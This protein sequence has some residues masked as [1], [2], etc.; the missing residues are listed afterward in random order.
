MLFG[1]CNIWRCTLVSEI[2]GGAA[3]GCTLW[4]GCCTPFAP[5]DFGGC[6]PFAPL[7][8]GAAPPG[9]GGAP[10]LHPPAPSK[11]LDF[12]ILPMYLSFQV[13]L[14]SSV[15]WMLEE[16]YHRR[17]KCSLVGMVHPHL[18]HCK[19]QCNHWEI[20]KWG[21]IRNEN[22]TFIS[23]TIAMESWWHDPIKNWIFSCF[24]KLKSF[25]V[26]E[27]TTNTAGGRFAHI[28]WYLKL[29]SAGGVRCPGKFQII[30][31]P[32]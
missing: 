8:T 3:R 5:P 13:H 31:R 2:F 18:I 17:K 27:V 22:D 11:V 15:L 12:G 25:L 28:R 21:S 1:R 6:T 30:G 32:L 26:A 23:Q 19:L 9:F 10:P 16:Y 14:W 29:F 7:Q 24:A 4:H 20:K